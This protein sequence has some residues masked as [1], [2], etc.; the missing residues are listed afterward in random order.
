MT[1]T[2]GLIAFGPFLI[3][4]FAALVGLFGLAW[5]PIGAGLCA[6]AA[7]KNGLSA[8][9][10]AVAG[11]IYS[12]LLFLP[13]VYILLRILGRVPSASLL[14]LGFVLAYGTWI[15]GPL[16]FALTEWLIVEEMAFAVLLPINAVT[17]VMSMTALTRR[18][19]TWT[20]TRCVAIDTLPDLACIQP[21]ALLLFWLVVTSVVTFVS[22]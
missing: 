3:T 18:R 7:R 16:A 22:R 13:W 2:G 15:L 11:A 21:F 5:S 6:L 12:S 19:K 4:A 17:L 8:G 1:A 14:R 10:F 9:R 20:V